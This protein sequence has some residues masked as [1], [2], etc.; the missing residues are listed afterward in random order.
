MTLAI[1]LH[2]YLVLKPV[3]GWSI[4]LHFYNQ[5][6]HTTSDNHWCTLY[7]SMLSRVVRVFASFGYLF[8][9]VNVACV[10]RRPDLR[11]AWIFVVPQPPPPP[12]RCVGF[13]I[14]PLTSTCRVWNI[15]SFL[16]FVRIRFL[17]ESISAV[18]GRWRCPSPV[19]SQDSSTAMRAPPCSIAALASGCYGLSDRS[20]PS[21]CSL[22]QAGQ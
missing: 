13:F 15:C 17:R 19:R 4:E 22:V 10:A 2:L 16:N 3:F 14:I 5:V 8:C 11:I 6:T 21:W 9:T 20:Q 7:R 1:G 18:A 12:R